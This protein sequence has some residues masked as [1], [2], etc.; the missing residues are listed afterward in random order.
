MAEGVGN[1]LQSGAF[2][3]FKRGY[4]LWSSGRLDNIEIN[5]NHPMYC[6]VRCKATPSMKSGVYNAYVLLKR[7][8]NLAT[9]VKATC[10]CAAGEVLMRD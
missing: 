6:H 4:I 2:R 1:S 5:S 8:G 9:I 10:P 7:D 3:A